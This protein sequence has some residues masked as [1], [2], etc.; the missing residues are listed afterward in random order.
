MTIE[1]IGIVGAGQMGAG[2]AQVADV[3]NLDVLVTD[4]SDEQL[5]SRIVGFC[6]KSQ[7]RASG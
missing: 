2:I 7:G 6:L 1:R 5:K 4:I 3:A